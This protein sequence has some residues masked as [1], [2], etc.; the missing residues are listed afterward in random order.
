MYDS[1]GYL[2]Y[3]VGACWQ[4]VLIRNIWKKLKSRIVGEK[5]LAGFL[6]LLG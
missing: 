2:R 1:N 3:T 4:G 5:V 6:L